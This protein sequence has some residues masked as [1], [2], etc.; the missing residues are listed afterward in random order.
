MRGRPARWSHAPLACCALALLCSRAVAAV[1][2]CPHKANAT[3]AQTWLYPLCSVRFACAVHPTAITQRYKRPRAL[4]ATTAQRTH[5]IAC[6]AIAAGHRRANRVS[7]HPRRRNGAIA[8]SDSSESRRAR[9]TALQQGGRS[10]RS[11]IRCARP[12]RLHRCC[13][14]SPRTPPH[15]SADTHCGLEQQRPWPHVQRSRR[16]ARVARNSAVW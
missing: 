1:S 12:L 14:C 16:A 5:P 6:T 10:A 3:V 8:S 13:P 2:A 4:S 7:L 9:H 11:V 15:S